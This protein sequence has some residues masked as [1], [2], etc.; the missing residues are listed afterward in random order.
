MPSCENCGTFVTADYARVCG[1]NQDNVQD[2][3]SCF[4]VSAAHRR[5]ASEEGTRE[6]APGARPQGL[7]VD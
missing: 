7:T 2:C 4:D 6:M 5:G 3:P 1:D